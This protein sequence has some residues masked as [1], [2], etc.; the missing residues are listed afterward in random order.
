MP[1]DF[2]S[3]RNTQDCVVLVGEMAC[4]ACD[5][6]FCHQSALRCV[7]DDCGGRYRFF[8]FLVLK[9]HIYQQKTILFLEKIQCYL[10][11]INDVFCKHS[12]LLE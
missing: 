12:T 8:E 4:S 2:G 3:I 10:N 5:L 11:E 7:I 6:I 1:D 9:S